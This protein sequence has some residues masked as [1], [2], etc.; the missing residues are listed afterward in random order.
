[1]KLLV[2][3]IAFVL[4]FSASCQAVAPKL[5]PVVNQTLKDHNLNQVS[6]IVLERVYS[7]CEGCGDHRLTLTRE[8]GDEFSDVKV[9]YVELHSNKQREGKLSAYYYNTLLK[10]L[11]LQKYFDMNSEYAMGWEDALQTK[12]TVKLGETVKT[13]RTRNEGEV[14]IELRTIYLAIDGAASHAIWTDGKGS[15]V[16][17]MPGF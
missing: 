15:N 4:L 17:R 9:T 8:K 11:E 3:S 5:V 10:V 7:G 16:T 1:M 6:E 13:V 2:T 12:I 14:P